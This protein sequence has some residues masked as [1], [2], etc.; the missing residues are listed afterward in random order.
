MHI[1]KLGGSLYHTTELKTWLVRLAEQ[2][3]Q[4]PVVIV[5]GGGPFADMVRQ[6]QIQHQF[7]DAHAH[8]M[9]LLA[10]SQ[11]GLLLHSLQPAAIIIHTVAQVPVHP[12]LAIW[13]PDDQLLEVNA[14]QQN[15]QVTSDSLALWFAQQLPRSRLSLIK[16]NMLDSGDIQVLSEQGIIDQGFNSLYQQQPVETQLIHYQRFNDFPDNGIATG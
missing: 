15:W 4:E 3:L 8:H 6:A 2:A 7:D 9:A 10:M 16:R 14:L 12:Q 13:L 1:V 11:F 5:P